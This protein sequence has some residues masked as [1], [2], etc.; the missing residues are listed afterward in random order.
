M[1]YL[2]RWYVMW[3]CSLTMPHASVSSLWREQTLHYKKDP[4]WSGHWCSFRTQLFFCWFFFFF[5]FL[6]SF[7]WVYIFKFILLCCSTTIVPISPPTI[8]SH[9]TPMTLNSTPTLALS[10][11]PLYM[12]LDDLSPSFP[13]YP[14]LPSLWLLSVSSLCQ[15]LWLYFACLFVD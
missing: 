10:I 4:D 8:L 15:Y 11:G 7:L 1:L 13:C 6:I 5:F 9:P 2:K 3:Q 14:H 12:F